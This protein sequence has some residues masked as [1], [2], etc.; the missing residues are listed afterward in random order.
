[1]SA[2]AAWERMAAAVPRFAGLSFKGIPGDGLPLDASGFSHLPF[3]E[4]KNLK[5]DPD[6]FR[7]AH[8]PVV[9]A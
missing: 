6:A 9:E 4:T 8:A 5:Y 3:V 7:Q 2:A 1:M